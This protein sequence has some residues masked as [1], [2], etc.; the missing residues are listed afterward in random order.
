MEAEPG[1]DFQPQVKPSEGQNFEPRRRL[2]EE[3][4]SG[5]AEQSMAAC[6]YN[7]NNH[8]EIPEIFALFRGRRAKVTCNGL[9]LSRIHQKKPLISANL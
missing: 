6:E 1:R 7:E 2:A 3:G 5:E 8:R 4:N 9:R